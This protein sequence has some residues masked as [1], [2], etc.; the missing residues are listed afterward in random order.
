[1]S[2]PR[3]E[4]PPR[5][6]VV[7]VNWNGAGYLAACLASVCGADREIVV[8]DNASNDDSARLVGERFPGVRWLA[9]PANLGFAR[10]ANRGL[11][12]ALGEYVLF[13]NPDAQANDAAIDAAIELLAT[14]PEVGL[15]GVAIHDAEGRPTPTVEPFFSLA[16][17]RRPWLERVRAPQGEAAPLGFCGIQMIS[18]TLFPK[19]TESGVLS[20]VGCYLRLASDGEAINAFRADG[21]RWRDCGRPE[22]LRPL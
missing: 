7:V 14:R 17:L 4:A 15:V 21:S 13:L 5:L 11:N 1:V 9:N 6:S 8:V 3:D 12:A 19:M 18:P 10:A 2:A 16:A 22:D 20:I